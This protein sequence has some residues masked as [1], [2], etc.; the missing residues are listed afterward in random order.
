MWHIVFLFVIGLY[1]WII[2]VKS[3]DE[4]VNKVKD[5]LRNGSKAKSKVKIAFNDVKE[6][7]WQ[8][9]SKKTLNIFKEG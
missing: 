3:S 9:V 2:K 6:F 5:V 7:E 8:T 4:V 1:A